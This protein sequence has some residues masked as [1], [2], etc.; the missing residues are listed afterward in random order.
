MHGSRI[1]SFDMSHTSS[2]TE[3]R[4]SCWR[5][6][7]RS[8]RYSRVFSQHT[9]PVLRRCS[10]T[11]TSQPR[12]RTSKRSRCCTTTRT[13][14]S[15][16]T[17]A[18]TARTYRCRCKCTLSEGWQTSHK[19]DKSDPGKRNAEAA[20]LCCWRAQ[21]GRVTAGAPAVAVVYSI[22]HR[23]HAMT[24][25]STCLELQLCSC[26]HAVGSRCQ[27]QQRICSANIELPTH[28]VEFGV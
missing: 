25:V 21:R 9:F 13:S 1:T 20:V 8:R 17:T 18:S 4:Q 22:S 16:W 24:S 7:R 14:S 3:T 5:T 19:S 11:R 23:L 10:R 6:H 27:H 28:N 26:R 2:P 15:S 12:W